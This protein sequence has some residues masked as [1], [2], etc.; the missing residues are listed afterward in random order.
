MSSHGLSCYSCDAQFNVE[1]PDGEAADYRKIETAAGEQ[2]WCIGTD[3]TGQGHF[4]CPGCAP[5]L[6]NAVCLAPP[7][8]LSLQEGDVNKLLLSILV[9]IL[10]GAALMGIFILTVNLGAPL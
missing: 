10:M 5:G 9:S 6:F 4:A 7:S 1:V 8:A 2:G 3:F